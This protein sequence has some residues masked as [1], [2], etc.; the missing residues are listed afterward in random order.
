MNNIMFLVSLKAEMDNQERDYGRKIES[1]RLEHE[2]EMF[3][4]KQENFVL[5]AKVSS[6]ICWC[7]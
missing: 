1:L 6:A 7:L 3:K 2:Q 4:L 5:S